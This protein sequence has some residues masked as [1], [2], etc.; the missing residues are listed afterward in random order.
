MVGKPWLSAFQNFFQIKNPLNIKK[1]MGRNM[2]ID[3]IDIPWN[4]FCTQ[5]IDYFDMRTIECSLFCIQCIDCFDI[6]W[7]LVYFVHNVS[8]ASTCMLLNVVYFAYNVS[9]AST[10]KVSSHVG[11]KSCT[12]R[13]EIRLAV[14]FNI[15]FILMLLFPG[16]KSMQCN[17]YK[18]QSSKDLVMKV[19]WNFKMVF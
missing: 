10:Y 1:V 19:P 7:N 3:C 2:C 17:K 13:Q 4:L 16:C 14:F 6:P 9:T 5:C 12:G 15:L 18:K 11:F 8:T